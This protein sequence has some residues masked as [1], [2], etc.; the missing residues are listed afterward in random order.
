LLT[1]G[2]WLGA[3]P[4]YTL[5]YCEAYGV[6]CFLVDNSALRSHLPPNTIPGPAESTPSDHTPGV[7]AQRMSESAVRMRGMLSVHNR[8]RQRQNPMLLPAYAG[9][10]NQAAARAARLER[11]QLAALSH[12]DEWM[13]PPVVLSAAPPG[14]WVYV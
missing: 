11:Q 2:H 1:R 6:N 8:F 13:I 9:G 3:V 7:G 5:V 4:S 10:G 12:G 14:A